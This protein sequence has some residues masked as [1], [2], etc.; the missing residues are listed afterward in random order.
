MVAMADETPFRATDKQ[1][2]RLGGVTG[3]GWTPGR[4]GNPSGRA[5]GVEQLARAHTA[6][7]IRALVKALDSPKERV[8]AAVAL[9]NRGWGL[10][11]QTIETD[12]TNPQLMHLL[13]AQAV[14]SEL[15]AA[16]KPHT[17]DGHATSANGEA[18]PT[19]RDL[20]SA[21]LPLE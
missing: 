2:P 12:P 20:L 10:P 19:A 11:K 9:L 1:P 18:D 14:S 5:K 8:P 17:I 16:L 4:S 3:R 7:A 6:E 15:V 21:P 13:A